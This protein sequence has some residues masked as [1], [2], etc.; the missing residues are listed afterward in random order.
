MSIDLN[1]DTDLPAFALTFTN[2]AFF[3]P[4]QE[5]Q[6]VQWHKK[7]ASYTLLVKEFHE[8]GRPHYHS[9]IA[10]PKLKRAQQLVRMLDTL[11]AQMDIG[12]VI[13]RITFRVDPE[14]DRIGFFHYLLKEQDGPVLL[15]MGWRLTWI[16]AQC[17]ANVKK[18]PHKMLTKNVKMLSKSTAS[19]TV[20]AYAKASGAVLTGK[21]S[22]CHVLA[23]MSSEGYIFSSVPLK[24]LFAEVMAQSGEKTK[25]FN[26]FMGE[27]HFIDE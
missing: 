25:A 11:Y 15:L 23:D 4:A 12:P 26:M 21:T 8:D 3:T 17:L 16:K 10:S 1:A 19:Q 22:L 7:R 2:A 20:L 14:K 6:I 24:H 27:L 9:L 5:D 18:I 13:K